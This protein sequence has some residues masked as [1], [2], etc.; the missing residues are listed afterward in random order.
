MY[1]YTHEF[2]IQRRRS[3]QQGSSVTNQ[4]VLYITLVSDSTGKFTPASM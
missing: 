3:L 2:L 4:P 1:L